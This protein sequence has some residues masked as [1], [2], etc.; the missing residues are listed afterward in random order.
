MSALK[1]AC[2]FPSGVRI[3][4][5]EYLEH[6]LKDTLSSDGLSQSQ[7]DALVSTI[8]PPADDEDEKDKV[9]YQQILL[10][11]KPNVLVFL[12]SV[13]SLLRQPLL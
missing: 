6:L 8:T 2:P 10:F 9:S 7:Y 5:I 11:L 4:V 12:F 3:D 1:T 13:A